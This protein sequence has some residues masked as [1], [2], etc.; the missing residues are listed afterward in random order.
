MKTYK[1]WYDTQ[2]PNRGKTPAQWPSH[3]SKVKDQDWES[4][5]LPIGGGHM[6]ANI[7]GRTDTERVQ[8]TEVSLANPYPRGVN[9]F[10]EI[11]FDINHDPD[12]VTNYT[13]DLVLND[14][15]AHAQYDYEGVTYS[16]EY[17]SSYPDAVV[18]V[19]FTASEKGSISFTIRPEIPYLIPFCTDDNPDGDEQLIIP[20]MTSKNPRQDQYYGKVGTV[21]VAGDTL[22]LKGQMQH[23][24]VDYEGQIC[25]V[26]QGGSMEAKGETL[27]IT[28]ADSVVVYISC[29]TNYKLE[30]KTFNEPDRLKK[31]AGNPHPHQRVTATIAKAKALGYEAIRSR[32]V[33]DYTQYFGRVSIDLGGEPATVPT[34][35]LLNNYKEGT[36]DPYLE[37]LYFNYGRYLLIASSRKGTLPGN[38]QGIWNQYGVAPWSAGYWHNINIQMNYWPAFTTNLAEMFESY[39]DYNAAFRTFAQGSADAYLQQIREENPDVAY[40]VP[41]D[42]VGEGQNGWAVGTGAWPYTTNRPAPGGHSGP[43]TSALTAK[44]FWDY[45]D[46]TRDVDVLKNTAYPILSD[47]SNFLSKS[48][49]EKDG[50]LLTYPSA[51]PE[52][53]QDGKY[54]QA[55]GCAFDQQMVYENHR[56]T[57]EA[58]EI[59]GISD[60]VVAVAKAQLDRLDPVQIGESGQIKEYREETTY[61]S[62]G[63]YNHRHISHLK[64]LYPGQLINHHKTEWINAAKVTL[65]AR[66]DESTGWAMAHRLLLWARVREGNRAYTLYQTLLKTGTLE[67][68]WDTHPPFQIDGNYGG[69]AGVAEMLL[70]SNGDIIEPLPALPATWPKGSYSGLVARGNYEV[71]CTWDNGTLQTLTLVAR[72]GGACRLRYP[73]IAKAAVVEAIGESVQ[74]GIADGDFAVTMAKGAILTLALGN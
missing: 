59:L 39:A 74:F 8:I 66:G 15:T 19:K 34:D 58:A 18:A 29:G 3:W 55:V 20:S 52:Q 51:S 71:S 10:A 57:I 5:S 28:N 26:N 14:A 54:Y 9:N 61:G 23:Y 35:T 32:H 6:G 21:T 48:L 62:I 64:A 56:D 30:E 24:A 33:E 70:Q 4:W 42:P 16:R 7:F 63:Q 68:L 22:F 17:L 27:V 53:Y 60:P 50:L 25:A 46:Y 45:Y 12:K 11:F 13:R 47:V 49:I 41:I 72:V 65:E 36:H 37:E 67:N 69:T 44:L 1:L 31:L 40:V 38:L 43:G 73:G 2:A